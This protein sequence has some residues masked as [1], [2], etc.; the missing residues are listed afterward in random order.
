MVICCVANVR[1]IKGIPYL[2]KSADFLPPGLPVYFVLVGPGMDSSHIASLIGKSQYADN[3]RVRGYTREVLSYTAA[4]DLYIQP[5]LTEG[6]G[7]SVI[8]AMCLG[9]P[10]V[11]SGTGGVEELVEQGVTGFHVQAGSPVS[12]AEKINFLY[13]SRHMLDEMGTK[14]RERIRTVFSPGRMVNETY[15]LFSSVAGDLNQ[16]YAKVSPE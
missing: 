9:K 11:V 2:I 3:F 12:I 1:K 10:V 4:C 16:E 5:S 8:E 7:R 14:A 6:L 15:D 13:T